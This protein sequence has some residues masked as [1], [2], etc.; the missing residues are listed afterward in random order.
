[1]DDHHR[2]LD[3]VRELT[4]GQMC[5]RV[6]EAVGLQWPLDLA[7]DLTGERGTLVVAGYHQDGPRQ[8]NMQQ[9]NWRGI[10]VV[11]AHERDPGTYVSGVRKAIVEILAGALDPRQLVTHVYPLA[12]LGRALNDTA[13]KPEG[14]VKGVVVP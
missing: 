11:N 2:I 12:E 7:S 10:D 1:M 3:E 4:N 13:N 5:Q 9:W 6:V 14:F 8:V